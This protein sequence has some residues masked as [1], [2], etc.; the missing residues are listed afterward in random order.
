MSQAA[1]LQV[2]LVVVFGAMELRGGGDLGHNPVLVTRL[3]FLLG[4]LG[5]GLLL[6]RM[7]ENRGPVLGPDIRTLAIERGWIVIVPEHFKKIAVGY[8]RRIVLHL[9]HLRVAG[10]AGAHVFVGGVGMM[11][12]GI[13]HGGREDSGRLPERRFHAPET[14]GAEC[15]LFHTPLF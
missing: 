15:S 10:P 8:L 13:A 11:S 14:A 2:L 4:R 6:W 3:H 5:G 12:A 9:D 7:E 1:L